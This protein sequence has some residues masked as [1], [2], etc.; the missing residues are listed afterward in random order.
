MFAL[1]KKHASFTLLIINQ[2]VMPADDR[3]RW[4]PP[5]LIQQDV[6]LRN[7][8]LTNWLIKQEIRSP[9]NYLLEWKKKPTQPN[10]KYIQQITNYPEI[11][12]I[13]G[14][15]HSLF[16][17]IW[18]TLSNKNLSLSPREKGSVIYWYGI[19]T[20]LDILKENE[21]IA[22][23]L[24]LPSFRFWFEISLLWDEDHDEQC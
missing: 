7:P 20:P 5:V 19:T 2:A 12:K 6:S 13:N 22:D 9:W 17:D 21:A 15:S 16:Q 11:S 4:K 23:T 8:H 3:W 18:L 24:F 1:W 10:K 14:K